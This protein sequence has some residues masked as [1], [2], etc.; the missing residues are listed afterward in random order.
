MLNS[1]FYES[2]RHGGSL[3][4]G[5]VFKFQGFWVTTLSIQIWSYDHPFR[6]GLPKT[7]FHIG[8]Q[9]R[10][11]PSLPKRTHFPFPFFDLTIMR[12]FYGWQNVC[13]LRCSQWPCVPAARGCSVCA[14][15]WP[16]PHSLLPGALPDAPGGGSP[17]MRHP[18]LKCWASSPR[19]TEPT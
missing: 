14:V 18:M 16:P 5:S 11:G 1:K 9:R 7:G 19:V 10:R 8:S 3:T 6:G 2:V 12:H 13:V 4:F 17:P 15:P